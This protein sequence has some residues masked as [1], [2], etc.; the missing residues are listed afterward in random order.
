[1]TSNPNDGDDGF[2][3]E[4]RRRQTPQFAAQQRRSAFWAGMIGVVMGLVSLGAGVDG[5]R[6]GK[7]VSFGRVY[8]GVEL[9]GWT[10]VV[11]A[12]FILVLSV[13]I[14]LRFARKP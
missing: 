3:S 1:M 4:L 12:L 9:P 11:I 2:G 10:V 7:W 5:M 14:L 8:R 6:T 13:W